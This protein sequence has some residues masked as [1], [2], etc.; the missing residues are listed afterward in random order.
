MSH[1]SFRLV[2]VVWF[3]RIRRSVL[4]SSH[5]LLFGALPISSFSRSTSF[6]TS[7]QRSNV[8]SSAITFQM[9]LQNFWRPQ[10]YRIWRHRDR[11]QYQGQ[12]LPYDRNI[13]T[14]RSS[15]TKVLHCNQTATLRQKSQHCKTPV[16]RK[17]A[18]L[19]PRYTPIAI[20]LPYRTRNFD[21]ATSEIQIQ[22]TLLASRLLQAKI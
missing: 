21:F 1:R 4:A 6:G 10:F 11:L 15:N 17:I 19:R 3:Q 14:D 2:S 7:A 22:K 16:L 9:S 20:W 5:S 18:M 12:I 8:E 13:M